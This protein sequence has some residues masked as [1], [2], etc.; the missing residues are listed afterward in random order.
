MSRIDRGRTRYERKVTTAKPC[1]GKQQLP[2]E[3]LKIFI[4]Q[5][6]DGHLPANPTCEYAGAK[7]EKVIYLILW[8]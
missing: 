2:L 5:N 7:D 6:V 4:L 1:N 8:D 3:N